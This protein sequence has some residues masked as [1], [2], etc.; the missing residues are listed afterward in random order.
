MTHPLP[1]ETLLSSIFTD[2]HTHYKWTDRAV[3]ES[4]LARL[5][6][7]ATMGLDCG[8]MSGFHGPVVDAAFFRDEA[9]TCQMLINLG[10]GEGS[11]PR[12][13]RLSVEQACRFL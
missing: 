10:Y 5:Y 13:P 6:D 9:W 2:A 8:P 1:N 11:R 12:G 3:P 7:I 4:V